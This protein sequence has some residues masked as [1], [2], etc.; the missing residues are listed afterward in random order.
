MNLGSYELLDYGDSAILIEFQGCNRR[1][2]EQGALACKGFKPGRGPGV[3]TIYPTYT[4]ILM[5]FN[6][7]VADERIR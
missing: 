3:T 2:L 7:L 5:S 4:T 6:C 1:S